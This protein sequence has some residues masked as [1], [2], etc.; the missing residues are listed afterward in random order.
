MTLSLRKLRSG[1]TPIPALFLLTCLIGSAHLHAAD[2][3]GRVSD[4]TDAY[5]LL[6]VTDEGQRY[7]ITLNGLA[8]PDANT[9]TWQR[10]ARR[11]LHMLLAGRVVSVSYTMKSPRGVILGLVRHG[12]ADVGLR[13]LQDGMAVTHPSSL[14]TPATRTRYQ[15]AQQEARRRGVGLWQPAR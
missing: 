4:V 7:S 3:S 12:G 6:L 8:L 14:L 11:H 2:L 10:I 1:L 15:Q 9:R 13:M 5:R